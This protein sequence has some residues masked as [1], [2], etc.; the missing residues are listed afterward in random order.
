MSSIKEKILII[1]LKEQDTETFAKLYDAYVEKIYRF[2]FFKVS[3]TSEAE[4]ITSE[5]FLRAWEYLGRENVEIKNINSFLY[6]IARNLV[7]DFYRTKTKRD[8]AVSIDQQQHAYLKEI[9]DQ[10]QNTEKLAV[11]NMASAQVHNYL[12]HIKDDYKE[13]V[14]LKYIEGYS[15]NEISKIVNK[16]KGNIRVLLHR[17]MKVMAELADVEK[18]KN[19]E[20]EKQKQEVSSPLA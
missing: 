11:S 4:D 14:I 5:V 13:I 3:S 10:N 8:S 7:I 15:T 12:S 18:K 20:R 6:Q 9:P 1:K 2:V 16:K 19:E 17:A